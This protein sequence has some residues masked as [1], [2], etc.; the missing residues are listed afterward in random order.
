MARMKTDIAT[1]CRLAASFLLLI[2]TSAATSAEPS[3]LANAWQYDVIQLKNG[4]SVK[5]LIL[6]ETE[7][8]IRFQIVRRAPGRPTVCMTAFFYSSDI[9]FKKI[10]RLTNEERELLKNRLSE[11]DPKGE[12]ER[13]R[14][15]SLELQVCEWNG[16]AKKGWRYDSDYF[17]LTSNAPEEVV[18][19]LAVRLE[20]IYLAYAQFLAPRF[21]GGKPTTVVLYSDLADYQK[22]LDKWGWKLKNPAFFDPKDNRIV[23]GS[24]LQAL[25]DDLRKATI[26]NRDERRKLDTREADYRRLYK[27]PQEFA[28][29]MQPINEYR[30][31]LAAADKHN[32]AL[33]DSATQRLFA[34]L[35]HESFHAYVCN[36][37]YPS[38]ARQGPGELPRWLN[39]GLAQ[40]FET[41]IV[42]AGELRVGHADTV[43]LLKVKD[44][45]RSGEMMPLKELLNSGAKSFL[46]HDNNERL[47]SDRAYLASWALA[48]YLS[49]DRRLLGSARLDAF[50]AA[51]NGGG[52]A[53]KAFAKLCG[54][55]LPEF[56][57]AFHA[58]LLKMPSEGSLLEVTVKKDS[59]P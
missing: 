18:R 8:R 17:S 41:A 56:E 22:T 39:E 31:K 40:I 25:G 35:Y 15:D 19:R 9:D 46:V 36:F 4:Y 21:P 43:R 52:D 26:T 59:G 32:E 2:V 1:T 7:F 53:E 51:V 57:K 34:I 44:A 5:G 23:C 58:W 10:Q 37:V 54:Q 55:T 49:F 47:T 28:A 45:V 11:L 27:N 33:F 14:M 16:K 3:G 29:K 6:E 38:N 30:M 13:R 42:E 50:I 24:N 20:Q 12:G 48:A